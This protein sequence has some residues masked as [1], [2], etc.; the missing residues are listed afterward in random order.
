MAFDYGALLFD[1]VYAEIGVPATI[2]TTG[3]EAQITVIDDTRRKP[4]PIV[5]ATGVAEVRSMGPG[6]FARVYELAAKGIARDTWLDA[7]IAFN[8]RTWTVRSYELRGSP[9][10]EDAGEVL[11]LLKET[12]A[13]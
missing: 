7:A 10:G 2:G 8:G 11:L 5:S 9:M 13:P 4:L 6:A 1:P 3:G 12:A